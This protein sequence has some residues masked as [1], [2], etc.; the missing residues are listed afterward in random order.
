MRIKNKILALGITI[1]AS[2]SFTA[3][4]DDASFKDSEELIPI[5]IA[6]V[7][8]PDSNNIDSYITLNSGDT[9]VK[10][11]DGAEISI[12]HDVNGVKKVCLVT[13]SAHIIRK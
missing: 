8:S 2:I 13:P 1:L 6:C 4:G 9:I 10:D 5:N 7:T 12:Y 11:N 3:C